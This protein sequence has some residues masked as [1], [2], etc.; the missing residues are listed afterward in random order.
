MRINHLSF[1]YIASA[2]VLLLLSGAYGSVMADNVSTSGVAG[3]WDE[4]WLQFD[5]AEKQMAAGQKNM[6][7]GRQ[8]VEQG[9]QQIA[10]ANSALED[11][12]L[13]YIELVEKGD[14]SATARQSLAAVAADIDR[15]ITAIIAGN[16]L[17]AQG[18]ALIQRGQQQVRQSRTAMEN[19]LSKTRKSKRLVQF[20]LTLPEDD[21]R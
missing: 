7:Q 19:G 3:A 20:Q 6:A 1:K 8:M 13:R 21:S 5:G 18:Y 15:E 2:F 14:K 4:G 9:E 17:V 11:D 10:A 16:D 12:R